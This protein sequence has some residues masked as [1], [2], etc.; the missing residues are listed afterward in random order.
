M[1]KP[2]GTSAVVL[3]VTRLSATDAPKPTLVVPLTAASAV[4]VDATVAADVSVTSPASASPIGP[5]W[6]VV[7]TLP[8]TRAN[9]P[10]RPT[11]GPP[12]APLFATAERSSVPVMSATIERPL[13]DVAPSLRA[14]FVAFASVIATAA[15]MP[16][17]P[18]VVALPFAVA[19]ASASR[20]ECSASRP[21]LLTLAQHRI[22][23]WADA[24]LMV[25]AIAAATLIGPADVDAE[26]VLVVPEPEPPLVDAALS[27][28]PRSPATWLSTLC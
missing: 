22:V 15:P 25:S 21:P 7:V 14:M 28:C 16:A 11:L 24:S 17:E 10:A 1:P 19:E 5:G 8:M 6:V 27:A 12:V 3:T 18:P 4:A 13:E 26:G 23:A 9:D 2:V 20:R